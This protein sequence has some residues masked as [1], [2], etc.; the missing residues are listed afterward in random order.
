[1][2]R[3]T[4]RWVPESEKQVDD[5]VK[6]FRDSLR[7][8]AVRFAHHSRADSIDAVHVDDAYTALQRY[9]LSR[10]PWWKRPELK[11]GVGAVLITFALAGP[12]VFPLFFED[13]AKQK[14][15]A[16]SVLAV[17]GILGAFLG[18]W[19]WFQNRL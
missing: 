5:H 3:N 12:D 1:M 8:I 15:V 17:C 4:P 16:I 18:L 2:A 9:G 7:R 10:Y 14:T 19:G 6:K 11:T 13:A